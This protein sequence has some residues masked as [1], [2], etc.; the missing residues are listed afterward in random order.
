[1]A[2][3]TLTSA[4]VANFLGNS[5]HWYKATIIGFLLINP[6]LAVSVGFVVAGWALVAEFI[7]CLVM[8]LR[9]YPLQPGGLLVIEAVALGL[10]NADAVYHETVRNFPVVMLLLFMVA[11][12]YFMQDLLLFVFTRLLIAVRSKTALSLSFCACGAILSAF[13]D[14]LTVITVVINV[15]TG[16]YFVYHQVASGGAQGLDLHDTELEAEDPKSA[17][18]RAELDEFRAFLRS[19]VMHAAVGT[20]LGG[21]MTLVGEPQNLII[22]KIAGWD[23][24]EFFVQ[25]APVS[26]PVFVIGLATCWLVEKLHRFGYGAQLPGPVRAILVA[27]DRNIRANASASDRARLVVQGFAAVFLLFALAFQ[28]A[29]VGVIGLTIIV[30]QTAFNGITDEHRIGAAFSAALPF[31][32]LLVTF[33]GV[34]AVIDDQELFVPLIAWVLS[35]NE[36]RQTLALFATTGALSAISDN[37][38][39]ATIYITEVFKAFDA[40]AISREHFEALAVAVNT[41]TNLP[42]VATPNGQAAFLFLLTSTL[43]PLLRLSYGRMVWMALPYTMTLTG[44]GA[45][46]TLLHVLM[47]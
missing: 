9:C 20:A 1:M 43:A 35:L 23:F 32:G 17:L 36:Q 38:F 34:V 7:F 28:A 44:G 8:A 31:A 37:V 41:G 30:L 26:L 24:R 15:A 39:V 11:G 25:V 2:A 29:E 22:G 33:F 14:A 5:P 16:F 42:S 4:F 13:L 19:L 3:R 12:I 47:A 45:L 10:T 40:G 18:G 27:H 21:V 46:F 6:I